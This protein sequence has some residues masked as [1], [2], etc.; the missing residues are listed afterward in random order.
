MQEQFL[1]GQESVHVRGC[2]SYPDFRWNIYSL[3]FG[4]SSL[5]SDTRGF[6]LTV[7]DFAMSFSA[8]FRL[9]ETEWYEK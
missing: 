2:S 1:G 9:V 3:D 8:N 6:V 5:T 4:E 7:K